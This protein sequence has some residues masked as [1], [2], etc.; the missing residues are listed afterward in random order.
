MPIS[1]LALILGPAA[2]SANLMDIEWNKILLQARRTQ[3]VGQLASHL[4]SAGLLDQVPAQIKRHLTLA[5]RVASYRAKAAEWEVKVIR[6]SIRDDIPVVLLKGCAY[7]ACGDSNA[8]GRFFSDIDILVPR[9]NLA[10]VEVSLTA[11]GWMPSDL[12]EYDQHYYRNWSHE[13]PP[14]EHV[15]RHTVIDLHHAIIPVISRNY[16]PSANLFAAMDEIEPGVFV[17]GVADRII[18]CAI[19]LLQEGE[20]SKVFR[21]LYDLQLLLRQHCSSRS[22]RVELFKRADEL[23]LGF[24]TNTAICASDVVF[25]PTLVRARK[26]SWLTNCL[27]RIATG[28]VCGGRRGVGESISRIVF[29]SYSHWMKMPVRILIPHLLRK[30]IITVF[31]GKESPA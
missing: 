27:V 2:Q 29:V 5:L 25:N 22:D 18:H 4:A 28:S 31:P 19:H 21:D 13:I 20:P 8:T 23:N 10:N 6:R 12:T 11:A 14:M 26:I 7:L 9:D 30:I 16:V 1:D 3:C 15:R 17:L 24:L